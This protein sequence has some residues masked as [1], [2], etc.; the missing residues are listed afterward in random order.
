MQRYPR[1]F[2]VGG[3]AIYKVRIDP[4]HHMIIV[5]NMTNRIFMMRKKV[6]RV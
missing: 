4:F 5:I 6:H 3:G 2:A 1:N